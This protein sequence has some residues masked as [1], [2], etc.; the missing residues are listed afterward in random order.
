MRKEEMFMKRKLL[1]FLLSFVLIF[2]GRSLWKVSNDR[3][4]AS[5]FIEKIK[6]E[7]KRKEVMQCK[8][9]RKEKNSVKKIKNE[10]NL[11]NNN[12]FLVENKFDYDKVMYDI[13]RIHSQY[14]GNVSLYFKDL[15]TGDIV[16]YNN[17]SMYSCSIIKIFVMV[18]LYHY[19]EL[20][21]VDL[22]SYRS[23]LNSMMI[24]S[25]NSSY[26]YLL[27]I[28]GNGDGLQGAYKVNEYLQ[29]LGIYNTYLHHGL[30]PGDGFFTD[31]GTNVSTPEDIGL[32]LEK[33]YMCQIAEKSFCEDMIYLM[34]EC[35]DHSAL[36]QGIPSHIMFSHKT[37][38]AYD[39]YLDGGIV[40][41]P[42][43]E[44][45]LVVFTDGVY[46]KSELFY[47]LSK[48]FYEL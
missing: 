29:S 8:E 32:V 16:S 21:E 31:G 27:S 5:G 37:G 20:G 24:D 39:Y 4:D 13:Q 45:I 34:T 3:E 9:S 2:L 11:E 41:G 36:S 19:A 17:Q 33:I 46:Q 38:W 25:D 14:G 43:R 10:K 47:E 26:N 44:Y 12:E 35:A 30:L 48:Y 28:L 6:N 40:Y 23:Y 15:N 42:T 18:T 22:N 7:V 1:I